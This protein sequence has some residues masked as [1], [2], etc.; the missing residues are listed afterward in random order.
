[1]TTRWGR[2]PSPTALATV[3]KTNPPR[4]TLRIRRPWNYYIYQSIYQSAFN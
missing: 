4:R 1:M 2:Q 3:H